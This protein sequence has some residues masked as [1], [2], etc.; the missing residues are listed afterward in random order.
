MNQRLNKLAPLAAVFALV[1]Y[2]CWPYVTGSSGAAVAT[3]GPAASQ[4]AAA[5]RPPALGQEPARDP[6]RAP[7][8]PRRALG[9]RPAPVVAGV[10]KGKEADDPS[11]LFALS[12]TLILGRERLAR[13][14]GTLYRQGA[15]LPGANGA[16]EGY[17][18][19]LVEPD[20]VVLRHAGRLTELHYAAPQEP[21]R[22]AK[23]RARGKP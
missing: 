18:L 16:D 23:D 2:C 3:A 17:V 12:A 11:K 13:I 9:A 4:L 5:L 21:A 14:N 20:K 7:A 8:S 10:A 15:R 22:V 6:F 19:A 1:T